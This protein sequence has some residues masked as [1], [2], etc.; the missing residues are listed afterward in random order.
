M[1]PHS[2]PSSYYIK[3]SWL[4]VCP[5]GF[6]L[7]WR[8]RESRRRRAI[9]QSRPWRDWGTGTGEKWTALPANS[10]PNPSLS[11]RAGSLICAII[12]LSLVRKHAIPPRPRP[13]V[14]RSS[15]YSLLTPPSRAR[16][17]MPAFGGHCSL[18]RI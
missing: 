2:K 9:I 1:R 15:M 12:C 17:G 5:A 4:L 8:I 3:I 10:S 16:T 18:S 14:L 7:L 13:P 11:G 6:L